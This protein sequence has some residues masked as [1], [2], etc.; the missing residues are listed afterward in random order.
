MA[1]PENPAARRWWYYAIFA[2]SGF[3]ALVYESLWAR[4]LKIFLGHAAYAQAL[5]LMVFLFGVAAGSLLAARAARR[6]SRPLLCYAAAEALL[7]LAAVYFHDIFTAAQHWGLREI[8]P[9]I[10]GGGQIFKWVLG[11]SLILP[12]AVLLG[13]TF[14]LLAAGI[15]RFYPDEP[16]RT[17]SSLYYANAAGAAAGVLAGGFVFV[18]TI[19]L[20]GAGLVAGAINAAAAALVWGLARRFGEKTEPVMEEP[21]AGGGGAAKILL[22]TAAITGMSSFIYEIVWIRM[23]SLLLG[24]SVYS[25]EIM[26]AVFIGGL[27]LGGFLIRRRIDRIAEPV[28]WL[29]KIQLAMGTA[30]LL[31]LF[32]YPEAFKI[33]AN[34]WGRLPRGEHIHIYHWLVGGALTAALVLPAAVCAGMTL[35]LITKEL[36]RGRGESALGSVYG[37][38]TLGSIAGVFA[39]VHWLLP[40]LGLQNA[41]IAGAL[42]DL[43]LGCV[44]FWRVRRRIAGAAGTAFTAAA[45]AAALVFGGVPLRY[46]AAGVYRHGAALSEGDKIV[47]YRDGK[48]ASVSVVRY[49]I[50]KNNAKK[51]GEDNGGE[52]TENPN[53]Y[54]LAIRTNGKSDAS[55]H[56]GGGYSSDEMTMTMSGLLPLLARPDARRA[57]NIGFGSG[58]TSLSLLQSPRL[59]LLDNIEIEPAMVDGARRLGEKIRPVFSDSRNRFIFDD[60][61]TV[62]A[63][64]REPYDIIVSEPSNPWVGGIGGLFT[65]EFY[66]QV[67]TALAP[68]GVFIQWMPLYESSPQIFA[69]VAAALS[70]EFSD[71]RLYL[72]STA[73]VIILAAAEGEAPPLSDEIFSSPAA[74]GFFGGYDYA[75]AENVDALF[76]GGKRSMQPYFASFHAPVNSDYFPFLE[77]EA[78]RA[79][80]RKTF[81]SWAAAQMLP[82]PFMEMAGARPPYPRFSAMPRSELAR[83]GAH[84][85]N[86]LAGFEDA[87][88]PL[89]RQIAA[90]QNSACANDDAAREKYMLEVSNIVSNLMPFAPPAAMEKIWRMLAEEPCIAAR[91]SPAEDSVA[92]RYTRFWRALSVRDGAA[93]AESAESLLG[94]A[95]PAAPSGQIVML[96][97]MAANYREQNYFRVV[98]LLNQIRQT[99]PAVHHA[100]RFLG[101]L[102]AEKI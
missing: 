18:P 49:N 24:A 58:L 23:I 8:L 97:A 51:E 13:A 66:R 40:E 37:A 94:A 50:Q 56:Y 75:A 4:Y 28:A 79:F 1:A 36:M 43:L 74:R 39:A 82:V 54:S 27:A 81:Y 48:T 87:A 38:N 3:A 80:F 53:A 30:A 90:V 9:H 71:F 34:L 11:A 65:R 99:N 33:Y 6:I 84:V 45:T 32:L 101:A 96:A 26:L 78:P 20:V 62:F 88:G 59:E 95:D 19:G 2:A 12:Q 15:V 16:G 57:A 72:S 76:I 60:A 61:K 47:F 46:A 102:A 5:V 70:E 67:K 93:L 63:R 10:G 44:L 73:D 91:L 35:P 64:A 85:Q 86:L 100:A 89:R 98:A 21:A 83:R 42:L 17:V 29:A 31:S 68:D 52:E 77:H 41:M 22:L 14:P 92:A 55:L 25:F 7:A 69:S